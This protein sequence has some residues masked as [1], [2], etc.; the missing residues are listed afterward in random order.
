MGILMTTVR[1]KNFRSIEYTEINLRDTNVLIG[2]NNCGKTNLLRAINIALNTTHSVSAEDVFV[3]DGE[4]LSKDKISIIDVMLRPS[5]ED[6][7]LDKTFSEFWTSVF[8]EK[9]IT[10]DETFG[11][12][13]GIRS[14][15]EYDSKFDQYILSRKNI[16]QWNDS[17]DNAVCGRKQ[18]FTSDMQSYIA[19]FY[20]DAQRDIIDDLKNKKSYF[21]RA[22]SGRNMPAELINEIE[23]QL[24]E[25][26]SKIVSNTPA[27]HDTQSMISKISQVIGSPN[28]HLSIEPV[29]R[30]LS[31]LHRGMDVKFKDG[32]GPNLSVAEHG[33]GTRSWISFLTLGAYIS[34]L[35]KSI[36]EEDDESEL[37]VVLALEEP[38]AHLHSFA[39]K[40]LF[41]QIRSFSGQKIVSTHSSSIVSQ[42]SIVDLVHLYKYDGKTIANRINPEEYQ[43]EETAKI[44][45]EFIHSKGDLLF[46]TAIVLAE[47]ITEELALPVYFNKYFG[48]DANSAGV[49]IL[50]IGGQNYKTFLRLVKDFRIPWF[51]FSDGE[52]S[53]RNTVKK[54][55]ETIF[56]GSISDYS[57]VIFLDEGDDYEDH[58]IRNGYA[59]YMI[60]AI[61]KYEKNLREE[62]DPDGAQA[63][64]RD[65]FERYIEKNNHSPAGQ[66]KTGQKCE[67]CGQDL[68]EQL[69]KI[70]DGESGREKALLDCCQKGDG[71]AKYAYLIANEIIENAP[72]ENKIP[73]K[74][75]ALFKEIE[76]QYMGGIAIED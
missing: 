22:T 51:I 27:L 47:G 2:Q 20:M 18:G 35:T 9:W 49:S 48:M 43:I 72:K 32:N 60:D 62:I 14:I 23:E 33:M 56:S 50:G 13:V 53:A 59:S 8:T 3:T 67:T 75:L 74:V 19:C 68:K 45:R 37:F 66:K 40:R 24:N 34:Y 54:A 64:P 5:R 55:V 31:D 6:N 15:I 4:T 65:F 10:T 58:L 61:N 16:T 46:S 42:V 17:V 26:N 30:S 69:Y 70:Y 76:K 39:Q 73:P 71:K 29:S 41:E 12:F 38:E 52:T 7:S 57:N 21:G 36:Q 44:Q 28:S 11:D 25:I 1:I 63:D